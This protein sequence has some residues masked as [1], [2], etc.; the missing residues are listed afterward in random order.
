MKATIAVLC[1]FVAVAYASVAGVNWGHPI[2][3]GPLDPKCVMPSPDCLGDGVVRYAYNITEG[4][5]R[6]T[7]KDNCKFHNYESKNE[8]LQKCPPPP[9]R[10]GA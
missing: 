5:V 1:L 2:D 7:V 3:N 9:G 8:C 10:Q 4:C 6:I